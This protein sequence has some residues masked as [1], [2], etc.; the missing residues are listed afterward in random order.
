MKKKEKSLTFYRLLHN[1]IFTEELKDADKSVS[2]KLL[3]KLK[4]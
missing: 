1:H 2:Y 3:T 4:H